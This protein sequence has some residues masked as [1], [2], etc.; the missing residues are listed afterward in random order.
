MDHVLDLT[1]CV[2]NDAFGDTYEEQAQEVARILRNL[3]AR[4]EGNPSYLDPDSGVLAC[5]KD[6]NG[7]RVGH[8][9]PKVL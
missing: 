9:T 1:L 2:D 3:A 7:N 6:V 8:L 5:I 4:L